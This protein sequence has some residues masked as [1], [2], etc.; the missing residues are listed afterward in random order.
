MVIRNMKKENSLDGLDES[1]PD[2]C[3]VISDEKSL[4]STTLNDSEE[5]VQ[6]SSS[7]SIPD[8]GYNN[9]R[10]KKYAVSIFRIEAML[11]APKEKFRDFVHQ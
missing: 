10:V 9:P 1:G 11:P 6:T 8:S 3:I 7:V 2:D 4:A 5:R